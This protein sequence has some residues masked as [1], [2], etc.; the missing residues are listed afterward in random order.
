M[1]ALIDRA[2]PTLALEL[3]WQRVRR[4]NRYVEE[5]APWQ[6]AKDPAAADELDQTLASLVEGLRAV[7]VLLAPVHAGD[8]RRKLLRRARRAGRSS[9]PRAVRSSAAVVGPCRRSS[10]CSRSVA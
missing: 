10:R 5:Q 6:L 3:I 9:R 8:D 4:L 7:N 1:A 2:E